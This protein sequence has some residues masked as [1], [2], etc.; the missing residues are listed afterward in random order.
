MHITFEKKHEVSGLYFRNIQDATND[1]PDTQCEVLWAVWVTGD[2]HTLQGLLDDFKDHTYKFDL[3]SQDK[4]VDVKLF[5]HADKSALR[6]FCTDNMMLYWH[7]SST[8]PSA[9]EIPQPPKRWCS[10]ARSR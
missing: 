2:I 9:V 5:D 6:I 8:R 4:C 7:L 10:F 3:V 1:T